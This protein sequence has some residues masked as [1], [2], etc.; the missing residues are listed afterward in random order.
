MIIAL[1]CYEKIKTSKNRASYISVR[2]WP[3]L[4][5][6][7]PITDFLLP[8][9]HFVPRLQIWQY[10]SPWANCTPRTKGFRYSGPSF[11]KDVM[12]V[13]YDLGHGKVSRRA[14]SLPCFRGVRGA[15]AD[16]TT[17]DSVLGA[18]AATAGAQP[19]WSEEGDISWD[20]E[21]GWGGG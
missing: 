3:C 18:G 17:Q 16:E 8:Q 9:N 7:F 4:L 11:R 13:Y 15:G 21:H 20:P 2:I 6:R 5:P 12:S 14:I 1:L 10:S 19:L